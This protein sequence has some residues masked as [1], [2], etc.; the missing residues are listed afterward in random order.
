MNVQVKN[1]IVS[2]INKTSILQQTAF[3]SRVKQKQGIK[4]K[5]FD[6][7]VRVS[8]LYVT[9]NSKNNVVDDILILFQNV[10]DDYV[11]GYIPYGPTIKPSAENQGVFLEELSEALRPYLPANCVLLRYDLLWESLWA[12]DESYYDENG[13]WIG[14]PKKTNQEIRLNFDTQNWNL[15][16][17]NTNILPSDTVFID[18][19]KD[20]NNL[21]KQM[22]PK[23]RYNVRLSLRKGVRVRRTDI[24][25][26]VVWYNLYRETCAR[27][28]I[29]LHDIE[30]FKA[31]LE[32]NAMNSSSSA[33]VELLIAELDK[34]PLAA[35]FLVFSGKRAAYLYGASSSTNRHYMATYALQWDA[36]KRAK[37]NACTEYD[38]FGVAPRPNPAHPMY[39]LYRFKVGFGGNLFHRMGCWDYPLDPD[40][41][42][43]YVISEMKSKGYH[44][45]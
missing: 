33:E 5:A 3:W 41:Y 38:M 24:N 4:S 21:L 25:D 32:T 14:P 39:G 20:E 44:L 35:M 18:L 43:A 6:I 1:K 34:R 10:G 37:K 29:C 31:V 28:E 30:Y 12:N 13:N 11:V 15:K 8:D 27:N 45:S 42:K 2:N 9:S 26:L 7:K 16:K 36:I 23:T 19:K 22:K 40:K 17:A